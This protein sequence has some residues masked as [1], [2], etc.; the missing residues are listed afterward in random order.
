MKVKDAVQITGGLSNPSKMPGRA[1]GIPAFLCK[2]GSKL[3]QA[4]GTV[5]SLCYAL[6]GRYVFQN[7]IDAY[8][9]RFDRWE[10]YPNLWVDAMAAL[11]AKQ[12]AKVPFF[13]WF[14]SGDLQGGYMLSD[15]LAVCY[16]VPSVNFW[17]AT[18]ERVI[19]KRGREAIDAMPNL[20]VRVSGDMIDGPPP[21]GFRHTSTVRTEKSKEAWAELVKSASTTDN[22]FCPSP[23]QNN[24][25]GGCRACWDPEVRNVV[26]R[27]H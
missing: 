16:A 14:D 15:I 6:K 2:R 3:R 23:L 22:W 7:V 4:K 9:R 26:Y 18:K 20:V 21:E 10:E 13:R 5:C 8:Q 12:C 24:E 17:L 1:W 19:A 25:C 11:I 27:R